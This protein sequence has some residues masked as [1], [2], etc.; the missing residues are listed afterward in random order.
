MP[1]GPASKRKKV[2]D[3]P[4]VERGGGNVF[5]D[6]GLP[7]PELALAK[8]KIVQQ[9][10]AVIAARKLTQAKAATQLGLDQPKV[11][12]LLR[13]RTDGFTLDTTSD[14]SPPSTSG[15]KSPSRPPPPPSR[16]SSSWRELAATKGHLD[17]IPPS[18]FLPD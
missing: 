2:P 6:L 17:T 3:A 12:A 9:L 13:G 1:S 5:A 18:G 16:A 14:S 8:A 4:R 10:R 7:N 11:S 15:S